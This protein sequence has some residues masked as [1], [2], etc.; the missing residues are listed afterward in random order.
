M[1]LFTLF[2]FSI[3]FFTYAQ[4]QNMNIYQKNIAGIQLDMPMNKAILLAYEAIGYEKPASFNADAPLLDA[5]KLA[6]FLEVKHTGN[7]EYTQFQDVNDRAHYT[8][9]KGDVTI[10]IKAMKT[11][12]GKDL[13]VHHVTY[14]MQDNGNAETAR[15]MGQKALEKFGKPSYGQEM[16]GRHY[17]GWCQEVQDG[18]SGCKVNTAFIR[19]SSQEIIME[20]LGLAKKYMEMQNKN[21][22]QDAKF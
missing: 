16:D 10:I 5:A 17:Y 21:N 9:R 4:A 6:Q 3:L 13:A 14:K 8:I 11:G 18:S 1:K 2:A 15:N 12:K 7:N 20:D 22:A 19:I